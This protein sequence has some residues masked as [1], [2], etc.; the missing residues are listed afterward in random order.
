[1]LSVFAFLA[2]EAVRQERQAWVWILGITAAVYNPIIQEDWE[3][4][5]F[6]SADAA[7]AFVQEEIKRGKFPRNSEQSNA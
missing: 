6:E 1:M 3:D 7:T 5:E 2:C 4:Q